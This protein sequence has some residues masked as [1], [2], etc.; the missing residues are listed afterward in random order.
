MTWS[1]ALLLVS[2][3]ASICL[4]VVSTGTR[5]VVLLTAAW[6]PLGLLAGVVACGVAVILMGTTLLWWVQ[7]GGGLRMENL[8]T[9]P[10][11]GG[12]DGPGVGSNLVIN[13]TRKE[14]AIVIPLALTGE[15]IEAEQ[16]PDLNLPAA[17]AMVRI[18]INGATVLD[19][20]T[21]YPR[22]GAHPDFESD[23]VTEA[24]T[25]FLTKLA[26]KVHQ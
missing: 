17:P 11:N 25:D 15:Y 4:L 9:V 5:F 23:A 22:R 6:G 7:G 3:W 8:V 24:I 12:T 26:V 16:W 19:L 20:P 2:F 1:R 18:S 14:E 13:T 21:E 10:P